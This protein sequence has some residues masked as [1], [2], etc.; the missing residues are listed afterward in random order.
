MLS[1]VDLNLMYLVWL[2]CSVLRCLTPVYVL[3][4]PSAVWPVLRSIPLATLGALWLLV[5]AIILIGQRRRHPR[6]FVPARWLPPKHDYFDLASARIPAVAASEFQPVSSEDSQGPSTAI[7]MEPMSQSCATTAEQCACCLEE[8]DPSH[9][10]SAIAG[11]ADADDEHSRL[12]GP[13]EDLLVMQTP[14]SH[15]FH[16][17]CLRRWMHAQHQTCPTCRGFLPLE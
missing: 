8:L 10:T 7:E 14:C 13:N 2:L 5:Q 4:C 11:I 6:F 16:A 3:G 17:G 12:Q 15:R 9:N 1:V